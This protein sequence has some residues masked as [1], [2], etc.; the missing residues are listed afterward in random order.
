M[1]KCF[2]S[3]EII[4]PFMSFGQMPIA[5]GFL[6][7]DQFKDEYFF[8]MEVAFAEKSMMFQLVN[9]PEPQQ[10]F[11]EHYAFF[12]GTSKLMGIHFQNFANH[13]MDKYLHDVQD[14]F[15]IEIGSNDGI[16]LKHFAKKGVRHLGIEPSAN[17]AQVAMDKGI[18]TIVEFFD[19]AQAERI[20]RQ[21]GQ[22]DAFVAANLRSDSRK[23]VQ[24]YNIPV[25]ILI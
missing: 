1:K 8:E 15:V 2:I 4:S 17:V 7:K 18:N 22:V 25:V 5:N 19:K 21:Y 6:S 20:V 11:N 16:M 24:K 23:C 12:S 10:M 13:V 3:D 14:P 9:Q